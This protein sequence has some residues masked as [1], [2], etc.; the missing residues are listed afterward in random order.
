[1]VK[2]SNRTIDIIITVALVGLCVFLARLATKKK[3]ESYY[4]DGVVGFKTDTASASADNYYVYPTGQNEQQMLP[5][6]LKSKDYARSYI[7]GYQDLEVVKKVPSCDAKKQLGNDLEGDM[8]N[9]PPLDVSP[10]VASYFLEKNAK[11]AMK[12][13]NWIQVGYVAPSS[14]A[15]DIDISTT[16]PLYI[17]DGHH[18]PYIMRVVTPKGD[19]VY[20]TDT[21]RDRM[22]MKLPQISDGD[23]SYHSMVYEVYLDTK[24]QY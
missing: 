21:F 17:A 13:G 11:Q 10:H 9:A 19:F 5:L 24:Y 8:S 7:A 4:E 2:S 12:A 14:S 20:E 6:S 1:M 22:I 16:Y 3:K 18:P 23:D 15:Y